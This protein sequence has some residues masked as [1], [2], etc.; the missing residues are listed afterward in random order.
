MRGHCTTHEQVGALSKL[1]VHMLKRSGDSES[2]QGEVRL[3]PDVTA[4]MHDAAFAVM[5]SCLAGDVS[6]CAPFSID[7]GRSTRDRSSGLWGRGTSSRF[8]TTQRSGSCARCTSAT[9]ASHTGR[10]RQFKMGIGEARGAFGRF[11]RGGKRCYGGSISASLSLP[12]GDH[13]RWGEGGGGAEAEESRRQPAG[14]KRHYTTPCRCKSSSVFPFCGC[15]R[16]VRCS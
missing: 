5:L 6:E 9:C 4:S 7:R 14:G 16:H 13:R 1:V 11:E 12:Y 3:L 2:G 10:R 8:G 15:I